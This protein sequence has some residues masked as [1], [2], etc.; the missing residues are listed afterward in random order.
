MPPS[1][2]HL[3]LRGPDRSCLLLLYYSLDF[4]VPG[5]TSAVQG[6]GGCGGQG[7]VSRQELPPSAVTPPMPVPLV[8]V[9]R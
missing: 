4:L 2:Q 8:P 7:R 1:I 6:D 3:V 5:I 9:K